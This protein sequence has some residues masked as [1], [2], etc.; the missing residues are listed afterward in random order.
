MADWLFQA[1][2]RPL[3][4]RAI[5]EIGWARDLARRLGAR[6]HAPD[7]TAELARL[8]ALAREIA[9]AP[10]PG[11]RSARE[12]Y[13]EVRRV[14]RDIFLK[15]PAIDF[16]RVLLIDQP[17]PQ[18]S[19]SSHEAVHRLGMMAVPGGRLLVL[20]GLDP[21]AP[22]EATGPPEPGSFWRPELSFDARKVLFSFK[23]A[24]GKSFHLFE[25]N[26]DGSGLRQLTDSD[27]DD[28]DPIYLPDG[29][30]MFTTTRGNT[31]VRCGP[32]IYSYVLA[33]CDADG[34]QHLP[35]QHEQRTRLRARPCCNDGRVVYSRWEYSD[36][37]QNRV[38][39]LW[40]TRPGRNADGRVVGQPERLAGPPGRA[41]PD[42][43]QRAGDVHVG[44][45]PRLVPR[46]DRHCGSAA[47]GPT[48]RT[49]SRASPST[50]RGPRSA[51][52]LRTGSEAPDYH[53]S[54]RFTGIPGSLPAFGGG[55]PGIGTR[56][57]TT[58]SGIYLMDV[59]GNREL[60]YE[61][62]HHA[63]Y[64]IPVKPASGA[65]AADRHWWLGR[66][67]APD[68]QARAAREC[69]SA[70]TSARACRSCRATR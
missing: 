42:S 6:P 67:P 20:E 13:F 10:G 38:Q 62:D 14:K 57:G 34:A 44:R 61:G 41:A 18:G 1:E 36:K 19:E 63:W 25:M 48:S 69:F 54:G 26:L 9:L 21:E 29:H 27:Y 39:S 35:G 65:T 70:P 47:R 22:V 7:F 51:I 56:R 45:A 11:R 17:T 66:A 60:I 37:D 12:L 8:D 53:S 64:A 32:Y 2:G 40:T 23:A 46:D 52:R 58:S 50:C 30:I 5:E 16:N 15:N 4:E 31:Y 59:H 3:H 24:A 55:L 43:G 28:I 49:G 33:R 68:R